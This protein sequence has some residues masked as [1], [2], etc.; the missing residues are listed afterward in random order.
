[1][2][3]AQIP[4]NVAVCAQSN[5]MP[6]LANRNKIYHFPY[7]KDASVLVVMEPN[8][9]TYPLNPQSG[10]VWLDSIRTSGFWKEDSSAVP[11]R[12][13]TR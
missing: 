7:V 1:D 3:L 9:N 4:A 10:I 8:F 6:H 2:K 11:L 12:V 13:F 5:L